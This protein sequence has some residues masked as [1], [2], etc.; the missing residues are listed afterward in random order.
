[1]IVVWY[2]EIFCGWGLVYLDCL[3]DFKLL[4]NP[5]LQQLILWWLIAHSPVSIEL[6]RVLTTIVSCLLNV[7][8][9]AL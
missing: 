5:P 1:L 9:I 6:Y 2:L 3:Q 4:M 7:L 8:L